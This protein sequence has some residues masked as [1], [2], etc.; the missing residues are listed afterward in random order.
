M[1]NGNPAV[2]GTRPV[3]GTKLFRIGAQLQDKE[4]E[5]HATRCTR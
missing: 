1:A 5:G 3:C 4:L 2:Q